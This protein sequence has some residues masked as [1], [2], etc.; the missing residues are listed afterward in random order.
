[1]MAFLGTDPTNI[2]IM[3]VVI[4]IS[5]KG[6]LVVLGLVEVVL[7][8]FCCFDAVLK[9]KIL[10]FKTVFGQNFFSLDIIGL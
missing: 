1:M 8:M 5:T 6:F 9:T 10:E 4:I 3:L 2:Y 7:V